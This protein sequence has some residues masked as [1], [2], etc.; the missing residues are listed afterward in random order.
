MTKD[1]ITSLIKKLN[2]PKKVQDF[3]DKIPFNF[4]EG[5]E[6]YMSP[7]KM[8]QNKK[9]HCF[10]GAIFACFCLQRHKIE[11]YLL[12]LKVKDLKKDSDHTLCIFKI[13]GFWGAIS[14]TN[15]SVLRFRDPIYKNVREL[16]MSFFHEYFLDSGEKTLSSF[17][18]PFDI[19]KKF[20]T[21]WITEAEDLDKIAEALD[22]SP[23]INFIPKKNIKFI[24]PAGKIEVRGAAIKEW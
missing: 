14:K 5:R 1:Q 24:R 19:W 2:T 11:N 17:S 6:T 23:H 8:F 12:D 3:L 21:S 7:S 13:N 18:K 15:H 4:E 9:A 20:G 22:K 10:E 16:A